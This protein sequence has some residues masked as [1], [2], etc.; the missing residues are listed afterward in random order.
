MA[1]FD[2]GVCRTI[3]TEET[4]IVGALPASMPSSHALRGTTCEKN[5]YPDIV[6]FC[7]SKE[8]E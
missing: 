7:K 8:Q 4:S 6:S 2:V 5:L 1:S 3:P